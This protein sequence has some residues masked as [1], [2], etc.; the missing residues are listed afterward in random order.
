[1]EKVQ[2]SIR[3]VLLPSSLDFLSDLLGK[4]V[5]PYNHDYTL[6]GTKT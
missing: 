4:I 5:L 3:N 2:P 6:I 1:M